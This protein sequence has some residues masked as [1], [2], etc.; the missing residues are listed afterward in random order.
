MKT[1][2]P[3]LVVLAMPTGGL[4]QVPS[5][6]E[7]GIEGR[8]VAETIFTG[9]DAGGHG[10]V[11]MGEV[12]RFRDSAFA[13][14]DFDGDERVTY[15]EFATWDPG[16]RRVAEDLGRADAYATASKIVFAIWDRDGDGG[17]S[18]REFRTSIVHDF[19]RAD[20]DDDARLTQDEFLTG[21]PI[22]VAMRAA[23]RPDL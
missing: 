8:R 16:F 23:I 12:E 2:L 1:A 11:T 15:A 17:L 7:P 6:E 3:L 18:A 4:A 13:G 10:Y 21:F 5:E 20:G 9:M 19:R 22:I 14:M